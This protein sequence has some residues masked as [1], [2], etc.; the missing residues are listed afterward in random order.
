MASPEGARPSSGTGPL[1]GHG[2]PRLAMTM[3]YSA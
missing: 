3:R 2:A 1:D